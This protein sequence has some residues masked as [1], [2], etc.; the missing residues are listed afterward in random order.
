MPIGNHWHRWGEKPG[1]LE[2]QTR[3]FNNFPFYEKFVDFVLRRR[4]RAAIWPWCR[5]FQPISTTKSAISKVPDIQQSTVRL[6][7]GYKAW[8]GWIWHPKKVIQRQ[9]RRMSFWPV[10]QG[11]QRESVLCCCRRKGRPSWCRIDR[12]YVIEHCISTVF[13]FLATL[14]DF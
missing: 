8:F 6:D 7:R 14:F 9:N 2:E 1:F 11:M 5:P 13:Q 3:V 4:L 10:R 12:I